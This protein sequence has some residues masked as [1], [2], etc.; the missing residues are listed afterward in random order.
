M[1]S[2]LFC[3]LG[4]T[5]P[6]PLSGDQHLRC[7]PVQ[8]QRGPTNRRRDELFWADRQQAG[9]VAQPR[10]LLAFSCPHLAFCLTISSPSCSSLR[11]CGH[12]TSVCASSRHHEGIN[13]FPVAADPFCSSLPPHLCLSYKLISK[14]R[15]D[16]CF[17]HACGAL[18]YECGRFLRASWRAKIFHT[19]TKKARLRA[20]PSEEAL[21]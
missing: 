8:S 20:R 15:D 3:C 12:S 7:L 14:F 17:L 21:F 11:P 1:P 6:R 16:S 9:F 13:R 4:Q 18:M 5:A 19:R 10:G 2:A